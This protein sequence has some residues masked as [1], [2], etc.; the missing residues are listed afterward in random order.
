MQFYLKWYGMIRPRINMQ[1]ATTWYEY[2]R[3]LNINSATLFRPK[4]NDLSE[5]IEASKWCSRAERLMQEKFPGPYDLYL[6]YDAKRGVM[7]YAIHFETKEEEIAWK[8]K[9]S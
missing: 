9:W 7:I 3:R 6:T 5:V 8:L 2:L 1:P 4:G